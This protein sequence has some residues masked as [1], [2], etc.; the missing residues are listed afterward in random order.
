MFPLVAIATSLLPDLIRLIA[1]DKAGTVATD[2]A[3][4]VQ[5]INGTSDPAAAKQ[6]V[7]TDPTAA[8]NLQIQLAQIALAASK[9]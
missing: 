8:A 6:K 5:K 3:S 2:V 1:G 7:D 9:V 4:A